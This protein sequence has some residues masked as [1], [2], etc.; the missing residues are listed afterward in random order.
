V[1]RISHQ[2]LSCAL[3]HGH[4]CGIV[5]RHYYSSLAKSA[6]KNYADGAVVPLK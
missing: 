2:Y 5:V 6:G 1:F 3:V 4:G